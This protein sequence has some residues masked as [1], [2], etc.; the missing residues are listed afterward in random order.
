M[1]PRIQMKLDK[2]EVN[3][4]EQ[5]LWVQ[6]LKLSIDLFHKFSG[7]L[8]WFVRSVSIVF[9]LDYNPHFTEAS[10]HIVLSH[11]LCVHVYTWN[12][13]EQSSVR[14]LKLSILFFSENFLT[15]TMVCYIP[16]GGI[17]KIMQY[18]SSK[19]YLNPSNHILRKPALWQCEQ[20]RL[21]PNLRRRISIFVIRCIDRD[22]YISTF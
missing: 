1:D 15:T 13:K 6:V 16:A 7:Q 19:T 4:K 22:C 3:S 10:P 5:P 18:V 21:R 14:V 17:S 12:S 11:I 20:L 2:S 8:H 9:Q